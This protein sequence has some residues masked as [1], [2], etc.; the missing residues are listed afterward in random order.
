MSLSRW[1]TWT[2]PK[3]DGMIE[4]SLEPEPQN[5]QNQLLKVLQVLLPVFFKRL[6]PSQ[7]PGKA[8]PSGGCSPT[9][10]AVPVTPCTGQ[11]ISATTSV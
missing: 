4:K 7:H 10:R 2:P 8:L 3:T 9:A 1:L 5:P 6:G 11:T